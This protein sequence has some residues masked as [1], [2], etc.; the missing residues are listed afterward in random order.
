MRVTV[1]YNYDAIAAGLEQTLVP[2]YSAVWTVPPHHIWWS[3]SATLTLLLVHHVLIVMMCQFYTVTFLPSLLYSTTH[4]QV[5]FS[6]SCLMSIWFYLV[7]MHTCSVSVHQ[8][9][10][11]LAHVLHCLFTLYVHHDL[12]LTDCKW[13]GI[14]FLLIF[15]L[16]TYMHRHY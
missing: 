3:S 13:L 6:L 2:Q 14:Y 4:E 15:P 7:C 12:D 11:Q 16:C 9:S 10:R 8:Y 5:Y 1:H